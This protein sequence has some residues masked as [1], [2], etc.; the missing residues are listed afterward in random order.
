[1]EI[2]YTNEEGYKQVRIV[3][4]NTATSDYYMGVLVGPPDLLALS[5]LGLSQKQIKELNNRLAEEGLVDYASIK[6]RRS[7]MLK[8]IRLVVEADRVRAVRDTLYRL[9]Q[10]DAYP[11]NF[12]GVEV[13][14]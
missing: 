14:G 3:P 4:Q 2:I 10:M 9:Y 12:E 7:D 5:R 1:M 6:G 13:D 8:V 11:E